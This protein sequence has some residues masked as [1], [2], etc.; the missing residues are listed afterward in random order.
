MTTPELQ[1]VSTITSN[2]LMGSIKIPVI[3]SKQGPRLTYQMN[4]M[5]RQITNLFDHTE[6]KPSSATNSGDGDMDI[7]TLRNRY[8]RSDKVKELL[9]YVYGNLDSYI[10]PPISAVTP[11]VFSFVPYNNDEIIERMG[12]DFDL[13]KHPE[14]TDE[15]LEEFDGMLQGFVIFKESDF[16]VEILDGNHRVAVIH[17][18]TTMGREYKN[19]RIGIQVFVE[20]DPDRQ[21]QAFV[22]MNNS[23]PI[24]KSILTLFSNRD[25]L[26]VAAKYTIGTRPEYAIDELKAGSAD[27]IGF[28]VINDSVTRNSSAVLSLNM[29][30]NM[31]TRFALGE[32]G[33]PK[34]FNSTFDIKSSQY[35]SLLKDF[36]V[37]MRALFS[38]IAPYSQIKTNGVA[39]IPNMREQYISLTGAGLYIMAQIGYLARMQGKDLQQVA[40]DLARLNW[41]REVVVNGQPTPNSIFRGGILNDN[42]TISNNRAALKA[43]SDMIAKKVGIA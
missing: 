17:H 32:S 5:F 12:E 1:R 2:D 20:N 29:V 7:K 15:V 27:Y 8:L 34:K 38:Y 30:K 33:T 6:V 28:D 26:A 21:R 19:L 24:D 41:L 13:F 23:T 22:D 31:I 11:D 14:R 18:L 3:V 36:A 42:G 4:L 16:H 10:L 35:D 25:A 40:K 37:Y 43:T 39:I 9:E